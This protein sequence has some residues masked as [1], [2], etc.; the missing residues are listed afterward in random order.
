MYQTNYQEQALAGATGIE[1]I[2]ALY[3]G[4]IRY[5][6]RAMQC[7]IEDDVR[8]RRIAVKKAVDIVMY[9]QARL[10]PDVGGK[11]AAALGEF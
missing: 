8:E 3:D 10:R 6:H 2:I 7:C 9:L 1:L 5:L 4:T 11:P